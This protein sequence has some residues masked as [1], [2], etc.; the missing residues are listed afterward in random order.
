MDNNNW[1][2]DVENWK[3]ETEKNEQE[4]KRISRLREIGKLGG[5]PIKTNSRNKQVNVRFTEKEFLNIKE[6]AEKL[7]ISVSEFIRNSALNKKL[8][9][10]EIDKT[11]TTYA[12]NF[13]RIKNI[14]KSEKV[15]EKKFIEIEKELNVVI[16]LIKNYLSL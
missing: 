2:D 14:F 15:Q 9:N 16:K 13:S 7:N 6:K 1:L 4:K 8:P 3:N 11:L 12:L 10:L 5:R